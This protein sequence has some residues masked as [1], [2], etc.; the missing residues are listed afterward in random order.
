M[1]NLNDRLHWRPKAERVA[2]WR[3]AAKIHA[4]NARLP[5]QFQRVSITVSLPVRSPGA[6]RDPHNWVATCKPIIDG[7]VDAGVLLDDSARFLTLAEPQ[8]HKISETPHVVV[9]IERAS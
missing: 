1:L 7:I 3:K 4:H 5:R 9:T 8:F 6:R 2:A